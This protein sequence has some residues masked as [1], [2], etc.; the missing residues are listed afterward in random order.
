MKF[1]GYVDYD[2]W[3]KLEHFEDAVLNLLDTGFV[4]SI[5]WIQVCFKTLRVVNGF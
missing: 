1:S 2:A 4:F 5:F 3:S